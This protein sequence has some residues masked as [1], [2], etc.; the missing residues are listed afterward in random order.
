MA[1]RI[2]AF[3]FCALAI[4]SF[5]SDSPMISLSVSRQLRLPCPRSFWDGLE[6]DPIPRREENAAVSIYEKLFQHEDGLDETDLKSN[7]L[8]QFATEVVWVLLG[9]HLQR[10]KFVRE[11]A[12]FQTFETLARSE[13]E[14]HE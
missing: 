14:R 8:S 1:Q 9:L 2:L 5:L 4:Q 13:I 7:H 3:A 12:Q 11:A 6:H 10:L